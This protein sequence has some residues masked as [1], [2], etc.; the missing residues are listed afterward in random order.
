MAPGVKS[1]GVLEFRLT[2]SDYDMAMAKSETVGAVNK[3]TPVLGGKH[4]LYSTNGVHE[5]LACP[6]CSSLMYP[7]IHQVNFLFIIIAEHSIIHWQSQVLGF[8]GIRTS[9]VKSF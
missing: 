9:F 1:K 3:P 8:L 7:P 5:L 4:G 6:V 2:V